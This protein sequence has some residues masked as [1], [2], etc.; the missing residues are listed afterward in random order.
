MEELVTEAEGYELHLSPDTP[1]GYLNVYRVSSGFQAKHEDQYLGTFETAVEAAVAVAK[2]AKGVP[3]MADEGEDDNEEEEQGGWP[4]VVM[5]DLVTEA[6]GYQL[7][8]SSK[9]NSGYKGV[10]RQR[11]GRYRAQVLEVGQHIK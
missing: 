11:D 6:E 4:A 2:A 10:L 8:L 9:S 5:E 3:M 7:A 1:T